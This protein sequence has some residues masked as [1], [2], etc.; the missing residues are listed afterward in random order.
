MRLIAPDAP[1]G[2]ITGKALSKKHIGIAKKLK[3]CS[4]ASSGKNT[5]K[6]MIDFAHKKGFSVALWM[7]QSKKDW[8]AMK[9]KGADRVTSDYPVRLS[10][11]IFSNLEEKQ[12]ALGYE[13]KINGYF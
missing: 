2:Y 13:R 4:I 7:V 1:L 6:E 10:S 3:C 9:E 11:D 5:T 12:P 8:E